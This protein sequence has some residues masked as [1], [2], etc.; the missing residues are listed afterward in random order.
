MIK[1]FG[2]SFDFFSRYNPE[3]MDEWH[4]LDRVIFLDT[5]ARVPGMI[6][7]MQRHLK[8][9]RIIEPDNGWIHH[10]LEEAGNKI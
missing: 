6:A 7:G 4:W 10:L 2:G 9:L 1:F 8:S 3:T 5:I